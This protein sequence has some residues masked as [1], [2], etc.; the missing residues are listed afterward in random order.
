[1]AQ[2]LIR[3]L[4][5]VCIVAEDFEKTVRSLASRFGI[6]PWKCW[7]YT[8]PAIFDSQRDGRA[9]PWTLKLGVAWVG[10]VQLEVIQPTGG[11]TVYR[12]HLDAHGEGLQHLLVQ[13]G[14]GYF[15]AI[16]SFEAAGYPAF[17][18]ARINPPMQAGP[19]PLPALPGFLAR[20]FAL[21]FTYHDTRQALGTVLEISKMPPGISFR[22]GV[23]L[24]RPDFVV[25]AGSSITPVTS[26][27][28]VLIVVPD[29]D[30][31]MRRWTALGVGPWS[32]A[33]AVGARSASASLPPVR[34][35]LSEPSGPGMYRD[36]LESHG[37][38]IQVL[39]VSG[40]GAEA[41]IAAGFPALLEDERAGFVDTRA[42]ARTVFQ[43]HRGR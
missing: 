30:M 4:T 5:Q 25:E 22:L 16:R 17:Q 36:L 39:G 23:R 18:S 34:L 42:Q 24:G 41:F 15:E 26:I 7:D 10:E 13:T 35:D 6:G 8:P 9:V 32:R 21:Q 1:M 37:P 40:A 33:E 20:P 31:A 3:G 2:A 43:L 38:G 27:D 28:S 14:P 11:P 12:E 29:L 19:L